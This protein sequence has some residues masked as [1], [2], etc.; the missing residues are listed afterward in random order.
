MPA[1]LINALRDTRP[2]ATPTRTALALGMAGALGEAVLAE[3]VSRS[4]YARVFVGVTQPLGSSAGRFVPWVI[5]QGTPIVDEAYVCLTG[6]ETFVP[7]ATP[8]RLFG[9]DDLI[10]AAQI[11]REAG[12]QRLVV[13]SPLAA[14]LQ[15]SGVAGTVS[16][17]QEM[18]LVGMGFTSVVV[19]RPTA[20]DTEAAGGLLARLAR[21]AR[22][23]IA[24]IVLPEYTK[25]LTAPTAARA[26]VEMAQAAGG[27]VTVVGAR[28]L[29]AWLKQQKTAASAR[30]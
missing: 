5:G 16:S 19:I 18:A 24:D 21:T 26:I 9:A 4:L 20:Q 8:M 10:T 17:E 7:K 13:V 30:R 3:L 23:A 29:L 14:L 11:A 27:G 1:D 22:R 28:E 15:M 25:V 12:A 2:T 6:P